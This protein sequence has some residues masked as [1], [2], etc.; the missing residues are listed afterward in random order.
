MFLTI[1]TMTSLLQRCSLTMLL[2]ILTLSFIELFAGGGSVTAWRAGH[3]MPYLK[4][5]PGPD[6]PRCRR[7]AESPHL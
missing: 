6:L 2:S 3:D 1:Q 7:S 5:G 4:V